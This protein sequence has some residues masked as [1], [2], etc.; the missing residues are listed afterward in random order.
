MG[1]GTAG[2]DEL[3]A[4]FTGAGL[5]R[6]VDVRRYP[7]SRHHPHVGVEALSRWLPE[8][9]IAY[10]A[11]QRLGGRRRLPPESPDIWWRVEAFRAYA[12]HMRTAEFHEAV[13]EL[14]TDI[15]A[16]TT[17]VMCS[18]T[19]WWRCHRRLIADFVSEIHG[20]PVRHLDHRGR[21]ARHRVAAG[22][23]WRSPDELVYDAAPP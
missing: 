15:R 14:L 22:A 19:L 17:A 6:V 8:A 1:H 4:L 21:L 20:F 13:D 3:A 10:R 5:D 23:R 2:R 9:G 11:D 12:A 7:G 18:E 16:G